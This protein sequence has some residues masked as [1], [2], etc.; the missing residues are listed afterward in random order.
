MS[1]GSRNALTS[2]PG[3]NSDVT[4]S[5]NARHRAT[6]RVYDS[7]YTMFKNRLNRP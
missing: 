3:H 2:E 5:Q 6:R 7:I 4:L 1:F